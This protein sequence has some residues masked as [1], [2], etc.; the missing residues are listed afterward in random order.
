MYDVLAVS[1]PPWG[2]PTVTGRVRRI[3][4]EY[5][6]GQG[7]WHQIIEVGGLAGKTVV[8]GDLSDGAVDWNHLIEG[9][10]TA[11]EVSAGAI[12]AGKINVAS[13]SAISANMGTLTAGIIKMGTGAK[14]TDLTGFQLDSAEIVGQNAGVDQV[15]LSSADGKITAGAGAVVLSAEG[16]HAGS[17]N[18]DV[19]KLKVKDGTDTILAAYAEIDAGVGASGT[20][21]AVGKG[22]TAPEGML[23]LIAKTYNG[24]AGSGLA[25]VTITLETATGVITITGGRINLGTTFLELAEQSSDP[26]A[27]G[28]NRGRLYTRDNGAGKTQLC[29]RFN[30][31]AVQVLATEP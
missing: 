31:G 1:A 11:D 17:G 6:R 18:A 28:L 13:L 10:V 8:A 24:V 20:L 30:T 14:D 19:N 25:S 7:L 27:P 4:E 2:G 9:A 12:T 15:V 3:V 22:A 16:I 26:A 29:V 5:G 23:E 21:E